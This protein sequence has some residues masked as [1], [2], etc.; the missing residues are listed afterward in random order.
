HERSRD[1]LL[2]HSQYAQRRLAALSESR[3]RPGRLPSGSEES[4]L[5]N[6]KVS[7]RGGEECGSSRKQNLRAPA[8]GAQPR[9]E[10]T[11]ASRLYFSD[12]FAPASDAAA[13]NGFL[14]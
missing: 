11:A 7:R 3:H 12:A 4:R 6:H 5:K 2:S 10:R 9:T 1:R 14:R 13:R 8:G